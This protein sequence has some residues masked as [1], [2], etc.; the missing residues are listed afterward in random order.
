MWGLGLRVQTGQML[1]KQGVPVDSIATARALFGP[2]LWD[3]IGELPQDVGS[4]FFEQMGT[5]HTH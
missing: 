3:C 2:H 1:L 4:V 5:R